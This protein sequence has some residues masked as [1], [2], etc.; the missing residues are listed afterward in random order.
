MLKFLKKNLLC[1]LN[2][3]YQSKKHPSYNSYCMDRV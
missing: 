1:I 3:E 2:V